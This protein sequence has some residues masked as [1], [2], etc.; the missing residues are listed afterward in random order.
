MASTDLSPSGSHSGPARFEPSYAGDNK[1]DDDHIDADARASAAF[2]A[3]LRVIA[4]R[5]EAQDRREAKEA[6]VRRR[7]WLAHHWPE[8]YD[9]R[10]FLVG[11]RPVCRRCGAL[12]PLGFA[13]AFAAALGRPLWPTAWDPLV[14]W[15]L[16]LPATVAFV[17]EM[18]GWFRYSVRWQVGTTLVAG[19]AFGKALGYELTDRWSPEFWGPIAIFGGIW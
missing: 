10:C 8:H 14:I 6:Q 1:R 17:G 5:R 11:G 13:V 2:S 15:L 19:L 9:E 7:F 3:E 4:A 12:Y 18:L 16:C